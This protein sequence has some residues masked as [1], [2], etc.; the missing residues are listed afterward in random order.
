MPLPRV[1]AVRRAP[2]H[3][4]A[5]LFLLMAV[6]LGACNTIGGMGQDLSAAGRAIDDT[7]QS[8]KR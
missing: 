3:L 7:A 1:T 2:L 6:A 4:L 5:P 8:A